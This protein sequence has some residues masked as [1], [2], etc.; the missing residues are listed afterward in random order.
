MAD[1]AAHWKL[2][3]D[4]AEADQLRSITILPKVPPSD[5]TPDFEMHMEEAHHEEF[6]GRFAFV[7]LALMHFHPRCV[8]YVDADHDDFYRGH[9][10]LERDLD[11]GDVPP[12]D[13][14]RYIRAVMSSREAGMFFYFTECGILIRLRGGLDNDIFGTN[15][16]FDAMLSTLVTSRGLFL[17]SYENIWS[18]KRFQAD[19]EKYVEGL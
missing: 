14:E 5:L 15:D 19:L 13:L 4:L 11:V 9:P 10:G 17:E 2:F 8:V 1:A 3:A 16:H 12:G 18:D 7:L 6:A